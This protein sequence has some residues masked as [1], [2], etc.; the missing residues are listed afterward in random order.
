MKK[1]ILLS[2]ILITQFAT[3]QFFINF[4]T[5]YTIPRLKK[6]N[7]MLYNTRDYDYRILEDD[8]N[9]TTYYY[10]TLKVCNIADGATI[11]IN[12][13]Y[14]LKHSHF[15]IDFN[16][17]NNTKFGSYKIH[18]TF[19]NDYATKYSNSYSYLNWEQKYFIS[20]FYIAPRFS[21]SF[22]W[23]KISLLP[24]ISIAF[25]YMTIYKEENFTSFNTLGN[26]ELINNGGKLNYKLTKSKYKPHVT[27][28][29]LIGLV[30]SYQ[31]NK[32]FSL[33]LDFYYQ[34]KYYDP[35]NTKIIQY[36]S[37][38]YN[39]IS[40]ETTIDNENKETDK[41]YDYFFLTNYRVGF[42]FCYTFSKKEK[43]D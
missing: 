6:S 38:Y 8:V 17:L 19:H 5:G 11:N 4:N 16:Y 29:P 28:S 37:E 10:P 7:K 22:N 13:G 31:L 30:F 24:Y 3:A 26:E 9:D 1:Y 23:K 12:I 14:K 42:G 32:H 18:N 34:R 40:G 27:T 21:Y 43:T 33:L 15:S 25:D 2:C 41:E 20:W 35:S 39:S 36:Y